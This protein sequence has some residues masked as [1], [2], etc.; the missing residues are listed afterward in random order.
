[1]DLI[2]IREQARQY[3]HEHPASADKLAKRLDVPYWWLV[4]FRAGAIQ[5]PSIER[6]QRVVDFMAA[7]KERAA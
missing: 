1:M 7:E 5:N 3:L 4:K 6:L 2:E